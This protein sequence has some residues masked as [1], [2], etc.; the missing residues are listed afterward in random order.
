[1]FFTFLEGCPVR[2]IMVLHNVCIASQ[3]EARC[4]DL[5]GGCRCRVQVLVSASS[6]GACG[7]RPTAN[8]SLPL[9]GP[10]L[11]SQKVGGE[12][13]Q[14]PGSFQSHCGPRVDQQTKRTPWPLVRKRTIPTDRPLLVDE[15]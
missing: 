3:G 5:V 2:V 9:C 11:Q 8:D 13:S 4:G 10:V 12:V 6:T 15:N 14:L 1:M 7:L